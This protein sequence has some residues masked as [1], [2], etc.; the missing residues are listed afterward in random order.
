MV[1]SLLT[2]VFLSVSAWG[3][4]TGD[5]NTSLNVDVIMHTAYTEALPLARRH[6]TSAPVHAVALLP[7]RSTH[8]RL[9]TTMPAWLQ[10][11][12]MVWLPTSIASMVTTATLGR[13]ISLSPAFPLVLRE[14]SQTS[15][16]WYSL[17]EHTTKE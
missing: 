1:T 15:G 12:V 14:Q 16:L 5:Y 2:V 9:S 17:L 10:I 7:T 6:V 3:F 4:S 13:Q 11:P 8:F